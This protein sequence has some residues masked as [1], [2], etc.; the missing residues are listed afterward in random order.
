MVVKE[1]GV[2]GFTEPDPK[3]DL[4][5]IDLPERFNLDS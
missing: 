1:A 3:I 4:S 2:Q 5:G